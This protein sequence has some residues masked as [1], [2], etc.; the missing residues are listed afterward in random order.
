MLQF[1]L[2]YGQLRPRP[3]PAPPFHFL[4][5]LL[6]PHNAIQVRLPQLEMQ[7]R[8]GLRVQLNSMHGPVHHLRKGEGDVRQTLCG[9][10]YAP[11]PS[12][13]C[14]GGMMPQC[15]IHDLKRGGE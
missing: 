13:V 7:A 14:Q 11:P 6:T 9:S 3:G 2:I 15:I 1:R 12:D 8:D 4:R 5:A 10:Q